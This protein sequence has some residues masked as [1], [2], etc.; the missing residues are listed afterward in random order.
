[1]PLN[2][3][4]TLQTSQAEIFSVVFVLDEELGKNIFKPPPKQPALATPPSSNNKSTPIDLS[5]AYCLNCARKMDDSLKAFQVLCQ[6]PLPQLTHTYDN[7][8]LGSIVS[9]SLR[10]VQKLISILIILKPVLDI[11]FLEF[12]HFYKINVLK[13]I[14]SFPQPQKNSDTWLS[15]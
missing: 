4:T 6:N 5:S 10:I 14:I 9:L 7:F 12:Y 3:S 11:Y 13:R 2:T 1:M 8:Q 15:W